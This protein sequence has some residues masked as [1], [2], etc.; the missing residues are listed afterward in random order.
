MGEWAMGKGNSTGNA[1]GD[2]T[3]DGT[4]MLNRKSSIAIGILQ[5]S[6]GS[7]MI[8]ATAG[9]RL[10]RR[11][12][13]GRRSR[14]KPSRRFSPTSA[15]TRPI[16][17]ATSRRPPTSWQSILEREGIP[18]KRYESGAGPLD[19][20]RAAQGQRPRE[21]DSAA[22]SHG[23]RAHRRQPVE[24]RSVRRRDRRRAH[25]GPRHD[26]HEGTGRRAAHTRSSR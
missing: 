20:P 10:P 7:L 26:G 14:R 15:S 22:A 25:L 13:T 1:T 18:V 5:W 4:A 16:R 21:A 23:R 19:R 11:R 8:L 17:R 12:P 24:A 9:A 3:G 6:I 2:G